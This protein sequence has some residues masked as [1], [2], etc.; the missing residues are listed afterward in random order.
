MEI[1]VLIIRIKKDNTC[2]LLRPVLDTQYRCNKSVI[3]IFVHS[4]IFR[5][6]QK[7]NSLHRKCM[8]TIIKQ[9]MLFKTLLCLYLTILTVSKSTLFF[10]SSPLFYSISGDNK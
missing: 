7:Q 6:N 2:K 8:L 3:F 4:Q 9:I 5:E 10:K 1:I